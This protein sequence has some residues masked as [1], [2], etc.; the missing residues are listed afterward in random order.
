MDFHIETLGLC[1]KGATHT[2][3][4][5]NAKAATSEKNGERSQEPVSHAASGPV[6]TVA[7][8]QSA[9]N[10]AM[11]GQMPTKQ[12][13]LG[14][15]A[16]DSAVAM[17]YFLDSVDHALDLAKDNNLT[18]GLDYDMRIM[19]TEVNHQ[20]V[21]IVSLRH[22]INSKAVTLMRKDSKMRQGIYT[23]VYGIAFDEDIRRLESDITNLEISGKGWKAQPEANQRDESQ[24]NGEINQ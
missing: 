23:I 19:K 9:P 8:R 12:G 2:P 4:S 16:A 7:T 14:T 10:N 18:L 15:L 5:D 24:A 21:D 17:K 3:H 11:I 13:G 20:S 6:G 22:L 1:S